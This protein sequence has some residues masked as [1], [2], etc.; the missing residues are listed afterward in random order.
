MMAMTIR[1]LS[2]IQRT[3]QGLN[4]SCSVKERVL[5]VLQRMLMTKCKC[6]VNALHVL[7]LIIMQMF[8]QPSL[9]S[10]HIL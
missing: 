5:S 1:I 7:N 9:D 4:I 8:L 3:G 2:Y 10:R 6:G